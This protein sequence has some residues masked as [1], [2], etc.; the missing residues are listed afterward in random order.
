MSV[1]RVFITQRFF[2]CTVKYTHI[3]IWL[4]TIFVRRSSFGS[5]FRENCWT[6]VSLSV[7]KKTFLKISSCLHPSICLC[8]IFRFLLEH[9]D[10]LN[11]S[12]RSLDRPHSLEH[13]GIYKTHGSKTKWTNLM[14]GRSSW[15]QTSSC[16]SYKY[17][18]MTHHLAASG[19]RIGL[20]GWRSDSSCMVKA[21][22]LFYH[23]W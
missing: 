8:Q 15:M 3:Y 21:I 4:A 12:H 16:R 18:N 6:A 14:C 9:V 23:I 20:S 17:M 19:L 11:R 1:W 5:A 7:Y 2:Y 10:V 22:S 13:G